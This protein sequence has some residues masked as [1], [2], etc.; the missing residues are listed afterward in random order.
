MKLVEDNFTM[1]GEEEI[2]IEQN[3]RLGSILERLDAQ[4][5]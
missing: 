1:Q 5:A 3:S 4:A 2:D